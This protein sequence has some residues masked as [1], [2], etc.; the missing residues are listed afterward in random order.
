[1]RRFAAR[2]LLA[3]VVLLPH[4][5]SAGA[6]AAPTSAASDQDAVRAVVVRLFDG[7]R[8]ADSAMVRSVFH[9]DAR[10]VSTG[11]RDGQPHVSVTPADRFVASIAGA[12]GRL[13][14]QIYDLEIRVDDNLATAW[15]FYTF[16]LGDRFS[17]CGHNAFQLARTSTGWKVTQIADS[18]RSEPCT[19][20][21]RD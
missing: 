15:M 1:M 13:D 8:A 9:P 12:P 5:T 6:Q 3:L 14:E 16:H 4:A 2:L 17:H 11:M 19:P 10:L 20:P 18:R 21:R 7:M